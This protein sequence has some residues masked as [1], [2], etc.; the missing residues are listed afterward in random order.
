MLGR[1][2]GRGCA[3]VVSLFR[4]SIYIYICIG[5]VC[6]VLLSF[7]VLL[8]L[9]VSLLFLLPIPVVFFIGVSTTTSPCGRWR[10]CG[11]KASLCSC[12]LCLRR[13]RLRR[14]CFRRISLCLQLR[15]IRGP[16]WGKNG[17]HFCYEVRLE[18]RATSEIGAQKFLPQQCPCVGGLAFGVWQRFWRCHLAQLRQRRRV[19]R[20]VKQHDGECSVLLQQH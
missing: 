4:L 8:L 18:R 7:F 14:R 9:F 11:V 16:S 6:L 17:L 19:V 3:A 2:V 15:Q 13:Q 20:A 12:C 1:G 5:T 10:A